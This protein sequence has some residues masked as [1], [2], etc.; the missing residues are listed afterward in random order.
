MV[1]RSAKPV[2]LTSVSEQVSSPKVGVAGNHTSQLLL[3]SRRVGR[4]DSGKL[5]NVSL[6][7]HLQ[8]VTGTCSGFKDMLSSVHGVSL[9]AR[10][11]V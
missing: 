1:P 9:Q 4:N 7:E 2:F 8:H 6:R 11:Y 5:C 3:S 10:P